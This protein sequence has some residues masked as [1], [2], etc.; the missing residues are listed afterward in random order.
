MIRGIE[1]VVLKDGLVAGAFYLCPRYNGDPYLIQAVTEKLD[2][3]PTHALVFEPGADAPLSITDLETTT[4]VLMPDVSIRVDPPSFSGHAFSR[5]IRPPMMIV[6]DDVPYAVALLHYRGHTFVNL[7]TGVADH[8]PL[9]SNT[10]A[11]F[12]RWQLLVDENGEEVPI[13]SFG[14]RPS[15]L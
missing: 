8:N 1:R 11:S 5:N 2:V 9:G 3:E 10:W 15:D 12:D 14:E 4:Y 7:T 6:V 13:A